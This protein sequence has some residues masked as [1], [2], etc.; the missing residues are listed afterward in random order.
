MLGRKLECVRWAFVCHISI[1]V[2]HFEVTETEEVN[3]RGRVRANG[4]A[5]PMNGK[6]DNELRGELGTV[7]SRKSNMIYS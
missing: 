3:P 6:V 4:I 5:K 7:E 1:G 2:G